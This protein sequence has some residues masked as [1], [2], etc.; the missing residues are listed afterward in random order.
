MHQVIQNIRNGKLSVA[1]V[2]EPM[3]QPG[4]VLIGNAVSVI[5]A[6]TEKTTIDLARKSLLGKARQRPDQVRRVLEKLRNE[7]FFQTLSQVREKLDEPMTMGYS[8]A[9][10]VLACGSGVQSFKPG[11]RVASNGAHAGVVCVSKHLC[12]HIPDNVTFEHAAFGILGAIALQG[13]RLSRVTLGETALVIGLGLIG[14]LSVA[15]LRAAGVKV[16][17]T[18]PDASKCKIAKEKMGADIAAPGLSAGSVLE[19]TRGLGADSVLITAST[20]SGGPIDLAAN[21]VR[22]KGRVVLVGVVGLELDRRPFY[23]KEAEFVVSC[24]YGPGRYDPFYEDRGH[25]YPPAYARWTEQR[26]IQAVLD[27]MGSGRLN[28]AP[29]IS[30]RFNIDEAEKA[31]K[32]IDDGKEPYLGILLEHPDIS[33]EGQLDR[34]V[35]L[36]SA[37]Q[38][39]SGRIGYGFIGVGNFARLVLAPT[40]AKVPEFY[41]KLICSAG[42]LNAAHT[43]AKLGFEAAV[44]DEEVIFQDPEIR[45]VFIATRPN[46]HANQAIR[47]IETGKSVFVEKPLSL[48]LEDIYRLDQ[49]ISSIDERGPILMVGF[50]RRFSPTAIKVKEFF[51]LTSFPLT[52]SI[53]FNA[54]SIP[55]NQW[56][57]DPSIGG[58]RII[59]ESCHGIDLATYLVGSPPTRIFA[60]SIGGV[61]APEIT[62]DQCFITVRHANGSVSSIAYLAGGDKAFPKERVEVMGSGKI[63]IIEDFKDVITCVSGKIKKYKAREQDKGHQTEINL[64]SSAVKNGAKSPIP[65]QEVR[66]VSVASI[67]AVKSLSEGMPFDVA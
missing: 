34:K 26:N 17:G 57:H 51:S 15:I 44:T 40:V 13:V 64:F 55:A 22:Q 32:L 16:I 33:T 10:V 53:R 41:P 56:A 45:A 37:T 43:G 54:G 23:F 6:G 18:D 48:T 47:A 1:R 21:A 42:G 4:H 52:V 35:T 5:S 8:S 63:A 59:S 7:G 46:L 50:N 65:W 28:V 58:G 25:D 38:K 67:L 31:Y 2:P 24:S 3:V 29:L 19:L 61:T 20:K 11:D 14:Q 66:S 62:E 27:L 30:H 36:K 12:A 9:G 60:Q 49:L 39:P